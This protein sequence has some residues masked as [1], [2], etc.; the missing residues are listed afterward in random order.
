VAA[1]PKWEALRDEPRIKEV[2][3]ACRFQGGP[4]AAV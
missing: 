2:V 1:D 4:R 3:A